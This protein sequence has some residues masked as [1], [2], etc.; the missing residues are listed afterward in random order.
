MVFRCCFWLPVS[1]AK[2][3][4]GRIGQSSAAQKSPDQIAFDENLIKAKKGDAEAQY[5]VGKYY[6]DRK[7]SLF[8]NYL[9]ASKWLKLIAA[10]GSENAKT[11]LTGDRAR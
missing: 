8:E 9:E 4:G 6:A 7:H 10:Q 5:N 1:V 2:H 3:P 11:L